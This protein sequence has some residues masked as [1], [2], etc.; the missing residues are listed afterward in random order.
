MQEP[1]VGMYG[2]AM[3]LVHFLA[4]ER[5]VSPISWPQIVFN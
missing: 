3:I 2:L 4:L 1:V 5:M